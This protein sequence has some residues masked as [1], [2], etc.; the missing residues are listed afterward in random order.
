[1]S[2]TR[3]DSLGLNLF[4]WNTMGY[5][6]QPGPGAYLVRLLSSLT[7]QS[8]YIEFCENLALLFYTAVHGGP[9]V[10]TGDNVRA[11]ARFIMSVWVRCK[12]VGGK[13]S[14]PVR[15][16]LCRH[17][18]VYPC[19]NVSYGARGRV[20]NTRVPPPLSL[21]PFICFLCGRVC[22]LLTQQII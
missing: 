8:F 22:A 15:V 2:V 12:W 9:R 11:C 6:V 10:S 17:P 21:S 1:M 5:S 4:C 14:T 7:R 18:S 3:V 13:V 19:V 20:S 16:F